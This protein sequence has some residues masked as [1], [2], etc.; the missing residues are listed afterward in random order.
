MKVKQLDHL[1]LS[2]SNFDETVGW[3]GRIFG[4]ELVEDGVQDG[5]RWGVIKGGD[6]MLCIYEHADLKFRDADAM[7]KRGYHAISHFGLRI[8]DQE[9]WE[10]VI[11]AEKLEV[12]YGGLI[13]WPHSYAW[14][15]TDPTGYTIEVALWHA[16][17]VAFS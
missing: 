1:N 17:T 13:A 2:V 5:V 6:A 4:M 3:Y 16:D 8:T 14:Y 9:E 12:H 11:K 15:I 7:Q 10:A